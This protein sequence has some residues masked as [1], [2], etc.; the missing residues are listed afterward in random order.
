MYE[1]YAEIQIMSRGFFHFSHKY[2]NC[3]Y[4]NNNSISNDPYKLRQNLAIFSCQR[5]PSGIYCMYKWQQSCN[6]LKNSKL[7]CHM[8]FSEH[9]TENLTFMLKKC[10]ECEELEF[11][12]GNERYQELIKKLENA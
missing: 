1:L 3:Q 12:K 2:K 10:F 6:F 5:I 7:Y 9:G 8:N 4:Q 11:L